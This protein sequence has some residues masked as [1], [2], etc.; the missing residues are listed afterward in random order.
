MAFVSELFDQMRDLLNDATD[1]QVP[2]ATKKLYLNRGIN[3]LWPKV[4]RVVSDETLSVL[5]ETYDYTIPVAAAYGHIL[6]V[7]METGEGTDQWE[8]YAFYDIIPGDEDQTA[9]FR[10]SHPV[11]PETGS[12]IRIRY[13]APIPVISAA[14]YAAAGSETWTGPD[15]AIGLPVLYAMGMIASR[16]LDDRQDH[17]RYS[18]TQNVN[19]VSDSDIMQASQLWMGQFEMELADMERPLP[20]TRD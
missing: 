15:R 12:G 17:T 2:Y 19:G 11:L 5:D 8:R 7:E 14:S 18:T 10:I 13:A 1:T 9:I 3:R 4:Y 20:P 6:S 16:R